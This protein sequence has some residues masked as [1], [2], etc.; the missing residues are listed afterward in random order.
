MYLLAVP[1]VAHVVYDDLRCSLRTMFSSYRFYEIAVGI[2]NGR[3]CQLSC[4]FYLRSVTG[5]SISLPFTIYLS[6]T[7]DG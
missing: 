5:T 7:V 2:C 1:P 6:L 4:H 3:Q